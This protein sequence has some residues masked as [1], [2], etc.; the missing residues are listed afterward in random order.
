V[1]TNLSLNHLSRYRS[2]WRFFSEMRSHDEDQ[3]NFEDDIP[4]PA[5]QEHTAELADDRTM[6]DKALSELP[7]CQRVPLVLYHFENM[8]YEEIATKLKISLSKVKT[9]IFRG[10]DALRRKLKLRLEMDAPAEPA[11]P[12]RFNTTCFA[13][14]H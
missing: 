14:T 5:T 8:P 9:D 13:A 12:T 1:A 6:I 7:E 2:R 11:P 4:E 3:S 10:R